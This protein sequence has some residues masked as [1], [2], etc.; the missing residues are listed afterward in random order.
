M[1]YCTWIRERRRRVL[2]EIDQMLTRV[3]IFVLLERANL[4]GICQNEAMIA[5]TEVRKL[6]LEIKLMEEF[7]QQRMMFS[8]NVVANA[9]QDYLIE[10]REAED[11]TKQM[12]DSLFYK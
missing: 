10:R 7:R 6:K 12:F 1:H 2:H 3:R 4:D 5:M 9:D 8:K 11:L